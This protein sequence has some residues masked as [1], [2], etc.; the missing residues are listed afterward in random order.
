MAEMV[1]RLWQSSCNQMTKIADAMP[2]DKFDFRPVPEVRSYGEIIAHFAGENQTYMEML[3]G[4]VTPANED[5]FNILAQR[6]DRL[7]AKAEMT[8]ALLD[9]YAYG[10]K[11]LAVWDDAKAMEPPTGVSFLGPAPRWF[12][13]VGVVG[14]T[15]EH[16]GNLVTY[17]RLN[18]IVPPASR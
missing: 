7:K 5:E 2:E 17:L 18:H 9:T 3:N 15:K 13:V 1:R 12:V 14:H 8:K 4:L 11:V 16:Y 6:Y 10:N